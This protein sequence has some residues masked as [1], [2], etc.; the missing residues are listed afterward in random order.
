MEAFDSGNTEL[1]A[2]IMFVVD[3]AKPFSLPAKFER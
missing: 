3:A 1:T 2:L